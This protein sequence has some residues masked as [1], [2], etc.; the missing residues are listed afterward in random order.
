MRLLNVIRSVDP[1]HGGPAEGL[2]QSVMA[3]RLLGHSE[4]VVTL[5]APGEACVS[6]F[7]VSTFALGPGSGNFGYAAALVPWLKANADGYDAVVVHGLWQYQSL[8]VWRALRGGPVPYFVYPHGM[9]DPWFRHAYPLKHFKKSLYW[10]LIERRVLRD[11]GAVLFTA[12]EEARLALHTFTPCEINPAVVGYGVA[13]A[14]AARRVCVDVFFRAWP[15]TQG[16]RLVLFLGRLHPKKGGDLLIDAFAK[17]LESQ[18]LL[19]LVMAGPDDGAG[20]R[21][22]LQSQ[23]ARLGIAERVTFTGMLSGDLKWSALQAAEVFVLPSHQENFGIAVVE[24]LAMGVPVL[25]SDKVNIWREIVADDAGMAEADTPDGT[26]RLL[27]RWL[28]MDTQAR[29]QM[30]LQAAGCYQRHFHMSAAAQRLV[31]TIAPHLCGG[32]APAST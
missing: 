10:S 12:T 31:D 25:I 26:T 2:R 9:L 27:S 16:R 23:A 11:A 15:E 5:D 22:A 18:P 21:A 6:D 1:V 13:L 32:N 8:A 29:R 20:T 7:P 30:K 14:D 28:A 24:A 4:E 17:V 3:S 19:H